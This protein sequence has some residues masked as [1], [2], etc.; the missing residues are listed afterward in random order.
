MELKTFSLDL[1]LFSDSVWVSV[2]CV[3]VYPLWACVCEL[4][5]CLHVLLPSCVLMQ[6]TYSIFKYVVFTSVHVHASAVILWRLMINLCLTC[7]FTEL[8]CGASGVCAA[9]NAANNSS[10][11]KMQMIRLDPESIGIL[12]THTNTTA[13]TQPHKQTHSLALSLSLSLHPSISPLLSLFLPW[14][15]EAGWIS[16][17]VREILAVN[18]RGIINRSLQSNYE[19]CSFSHTHTCAW[20]STQN[21]YPHIHKRIQSIS[22]VALSPA[23][24][25]GTS[26]ISSFILDN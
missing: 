10:N 23:Y 9:C 6:S 17:G 7:L 15:E 19:C 1:G 3:W 2:I 11:E 12:S 22:K 4:S 16:A 20:K 21:S 13:N 24:E 18:N 26:E 25:N 5:S 8:L 14:G